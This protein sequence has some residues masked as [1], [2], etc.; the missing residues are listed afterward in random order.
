MKT[1]LECVPCFLRQSLEA[2]RM[3]TTDIQI[4]E[5]IIKEVMEYLQTISYEKSPPEISRKVHH[6]IRTLS[7][8]PD[9]YKQSKIQSNIAA[10]KL[11][12]FLKQRVNQSEDPLITAITLAIIGN[13][14]DFG[15]SNRFAV[16]DM[17]NKPLDATFS[18]KTYP[19][20][21]NAYGKA[22]TILYLAD[23]AGE[24][25]FDKLLIEELIHQ[26]KQIFYAVKTNPII[27][28]ATLEDAL[29]AGIDQYASIIQVDKGQSLST[30][31]VLLPYAS[32][33]FMN[34]FNTVDLVI[35]KGQGNYESLND[36]TR[37]I[38]FLLTVK[39][40]L[41]AEDVGATLASLIFEV[42]RG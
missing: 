14:I 42:N 16:E 4:H 20:F 36:Q 11:Y 8:T 5:A 12:P 1:N 34:L 35:S 37:E 25:F 7:D 19:L 38:F 30:P 28:D 23:N 41:I 33:E 27:N 22:S 2:A 40:P 24:V 18:E 9:P 31:G 39:C 10:E 6:I 17:L 26:K 21:K 32:T 15:T 3:A 13:V 29:Y